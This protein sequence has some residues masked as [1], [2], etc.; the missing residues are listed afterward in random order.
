MRLLYLYFVLLIGI[1]ILLGSI[2]WSTPPEN[3]TG[4]IH[5]SFPTMQHSGTSVAESADAKW[6]AYFF[7]VGI[8]LI[9][10]LTLALGAQKSSPS[11]N[12]FIIRLIVTGALIYLFAFTA[13]VI[14]Y[15]QF[16][17]EQ[18]IKYVLGFPLPTALMLF[19]L[20]AAPFVFTIFYILKFD[21]WIITPE[22]LQ[23][24]RTIVAARREAQKSDSAS[25]H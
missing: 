25:S 7:G 8:L 5:E 3:A 15:W 12:R 2:F 11:K 24:F 4:F 22:E 14:A 1:L 10:V 23:Q 6:L 19:A 13:M 21:D 20:G 16:T 17:G 9:F 18:S